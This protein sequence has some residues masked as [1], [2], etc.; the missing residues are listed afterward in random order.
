MSNEKG[1]LQ[2]EIYPEEKRLS[3][4]FA[5]PGAT[6]SY[7]KKR[8]I[9]RKNDFDEEFCPLI[10]LSRGGMRFASREKLKTGTKLFTQ[11]SIPGERSTLTL[12]GEVRWVSTG[13]SQAF[14]YQLGVQFNP[15]GKNKG[16]NYPGNLVKIIALENKFTEPDQARPEA[17]D[18]YQIEDS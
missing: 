12:S 17:S 13:T 8:L 11:L 16:Q 18:E 15:Y 10:N 1:R 5:I 6:V 9:F 4:R 14:P 7:K 3:Q 2:Q